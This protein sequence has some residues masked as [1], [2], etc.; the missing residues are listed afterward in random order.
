MAT[1]E[2][3]RSGIQAVLQD[4]ARQSAASDDM[5]V[6]TIFDPEHDHYQVVNVG[7]RKDRRIYGTVLHID[8]KEGKAWIQHNATEMDV[9]EE[10][11]KRGLS[12]EDIVIG[13][14]A[15]YKRRFT[16]FAVG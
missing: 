4:Y 1:L 11:V 3:L 2:V 10:L 8:I 16:G 14:H 13:F 15:P 6:Q 5:D 7:W 12:K 9:A